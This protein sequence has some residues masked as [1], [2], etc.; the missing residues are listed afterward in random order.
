MKSAA[1]TSG[2]R[3][4]NLRE[5]VYASIRSRLQRG[6]I[7]HE[8]RLVDY[9]LAEEMGVSRM[10]VREALLQLV[11]E[12]V[13]DGTSRGF[14]LRRFTVDEI[15]E[16]FEIR[17]LLEPPAAAMAARS[18]TKAALKRLEEICSEARSA[19]AAGAIRRVIIANA[20]FRDC[21]LDL[22]PNAHLRQEI[23]RFGDY[24]QAVRLETLQDSFYRQDSVVR[25][26]A[27]VDAFRRRDEAKASD[28]MS[29]Q[30]KGALSAFVERLSRR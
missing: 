17:H 18:V 27:V 24:V 26:E 14:I 22:V 28:A 11:S 12:G 7:G 25:L 1:A 8:D 5:Q 2:V 6:E 21:W 23:V 16:V 30:L 20:E 9:D 29:A 10:P 15:R 4:Q 13:L 3:K 19:S